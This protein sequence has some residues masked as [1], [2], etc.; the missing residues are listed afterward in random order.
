MC[1]KRKQKSNATD[2]WKLWQRYKNKH[3]LKVTFPQG[4]LPSINHQLRTVGCNQVFLAR[5]LAD[6]SHS[7]HFR[8]CWY[9]KCMIVNYFIF[10]NKYRQI[11]LLL[12][13]H[14][15]PSL[16]LPCLLVLHTSFQISDFLR[17]PLRKSECGTTINS[18][19]YH[20]KLQ[21]SPVSSSASH[22]LMSY[23]SDLFHTSVGFLSPLSEFWR[24]A[25]DLL[26]ALVKSFW[27]S[28]SPYKWFK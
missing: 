16:H 15:S 5:F 10:T 12:L 4:L 28:L 2:H 17:F 19:S 18:F 22:A 26:L 11:L 21:N 7:Q 9:D 27:S 25:L 20:Y 14:L 24:P 1:Q 3:L 13:H 6:L 8:F 23:A